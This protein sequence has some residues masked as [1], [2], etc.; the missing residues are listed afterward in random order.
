MENGWRLSIHRA[1]SEIPVSEKAAGL[2]R[3]TRIDIGIGAYCLAALCA[4]ETC[5]GTGISVR[6]W[7]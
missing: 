2:C 6:C 7:P 5:C 4:A 3:V 1:F